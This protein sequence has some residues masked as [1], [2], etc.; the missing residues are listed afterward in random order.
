MRA[1]DSQMHILANFSPASKV[2]LRGSSSTCEK[3]P[4]LTSQKFLAYPN[5]PRYK[6]LDKSVK[7]RFG[8]SQP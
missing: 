1:C 6:F 2:A 5:Y 4:I 8:A 7:V 3:F